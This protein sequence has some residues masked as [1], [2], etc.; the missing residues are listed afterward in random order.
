MCFWG[1]AFGNIYDSILVYTY[2][3]VYIASKNPESILIRNKMNDEYIILI[4]QNSYIK[5]KI[6]FYAINVRN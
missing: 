1:L 3:G 5:Y 2:T 6:L 4:F